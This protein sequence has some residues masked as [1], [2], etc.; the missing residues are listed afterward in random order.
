MLAYSQ[1][2]QFLK[3][4]DQ[5]EKS[6]SNSIYNKGYLKIKIKTKLHKPNSALFSRKGKY[7]FRII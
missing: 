7:S 4:L 6:Y 5:H 1:R 3:E 2:I